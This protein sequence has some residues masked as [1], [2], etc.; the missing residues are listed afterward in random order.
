MILVLSI[1]FFGTWWVASGT[2]EPAPRSPPSCSASSLDTQWDVS[3]P[4]A[5]HSQSISSLHVLLGTLAVPDSTACSLLAVTAADR[6]AIERSA[7]RL[8]DRG[9]PG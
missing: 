6:A 4:N 2:T 7:A 3:A 9:E 5:A 1:A 8:L